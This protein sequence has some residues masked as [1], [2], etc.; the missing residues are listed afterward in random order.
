[1][2]FAVGP[3][4]PLFVALEALHLRPE[5]LEH[6]ID[7][8]GRRRRAADGPDTEAA[9]VL[10]QVLRRLPGVSDGPP[11]HREERLRP[12]ARRHGNRHQMG[13]AVWEQADGMEVARFV[14]GAAWAWC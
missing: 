10:L 8:A 4:R 12:A 9:H 5:R 7:E 13:G 3:E 14:V 2:G 6:E 11:I 1:M